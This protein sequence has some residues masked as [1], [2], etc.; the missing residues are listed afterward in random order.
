METSGPDTASSYNRG[1]FQTSTGA[2]STPQLAGLRNQVW[3]AL[4]LAR[5]DILQRYRGSRL[6]W[7]WA[8]IT[9]VLMLGVYTLA[10]KY[11]FK[12]QWHGAATGTVDFALQ[13]FAGLLL[14]Q[15]AAEVWSRSP[16]LIVDQPH[17]VKKVVFPLMLLPCA[18]VFSAVFHAALALTL[19]VVAALVR[20]AALHA[21]WLLLPLLL[22]PMVVLL[23]ASSLLLS[24][25]GVYLR[26]LT[27]VVAVGV[28][29]LQFLS[30]VFYPVAAL[31]AWLQPVL[32]WNPLSAPIEQLRAIVFGGPAPPLL[33]W[34]QFA[35]V[36]GVLAAVAV[37]IHRR[38]REGF[39]DV[40]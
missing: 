8:V 7:L 5:R 20:G 38:V 31:P 30:P 26:D 4:Q 6:G 19:L 35:V 24:S 18:P 16:R 17:L 32:W 3:L 27:Q 33:A 10:F 39:A 9:P 21:G 28:A 25:L 36:A 22:L 29:L 34:A 37:G 15:A 23:W 14:F 1:V 12:V 40:L 13:L 2:R 11:V